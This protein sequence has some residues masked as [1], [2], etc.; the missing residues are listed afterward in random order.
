MMVFYFPIGEWLGY[1]PF[2]FTPRPSFLLPAHL[3]TDLLLVMSTPAIDVTDYSR[4]WTIPWMSRLDSGGL[5]GKI[6]GQ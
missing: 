2:S 5:V 4:N 6:R 1:N 3:R